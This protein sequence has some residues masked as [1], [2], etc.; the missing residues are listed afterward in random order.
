MNPLARELLGIIDGRIAEERKAS[1]ALD[2]YGGWAAAMRKRPDILLAYNRAAA[3]DKDTDF[4]DEWRLVASEQALASLASK[5]A[6]A[7]VPIEEAIHIKQ[8]ENPSL[9][10][11][12]AWDIVQ[13]ENPRLVDAYNQAAGHPPGATTPEII[14][15]NQALIDQCVRN[16]RQGNPQLLYP[17]AYAQ[18][19]KERPDLFWR[20]KDA[21]KRKHAIPSS[22][23]APIEA[24][25]P[26]PQGKVNMSA[27]PL[28]AEILA[29]DLEIAKARA[30]NPRLNYAQAWCQIVREPTGAELVKQYNSKA[31]RV[32]VGR[33]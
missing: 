2:Y 28:A 30:A 24:G 9:G 19:E 3:A 4:R 29:I 21:K 10:Y 6:A 25:A 17:E 16:L 7:L 5:L 1:P 33:A 20:L 18:V 11:G 15:R 8:H 31:A 27:N 12:E 26:G 23:T 32:F 22:L 13:K 14:A